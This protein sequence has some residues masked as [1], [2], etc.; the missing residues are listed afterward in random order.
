MK[1]DLTDIIIAV[2]S[3]ISAFATV[4]LALYNGKALTLIKE[5]Q[6]SDAFFRSLPHRM[7]IY[8]NLYKYLDD[9]Q[10][11]D[12]KLLWKNDQSTLSDLK[13]NLRNAEYWYPDSSTT[14][15]IYAIIKG[16]NENIEKYIV[17][18]DEYDKISNNGSAESKDLEDRCSNSGKSL[19]YELSSLL[20]A[21]QPILQFNELSC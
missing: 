3:G 8:D 11:S 17:A 6:H 15:D 13:T 9:F 4:C 21:M 16:L 10:H 5:Q 19:I 18:K 7:E 1:M 14:K 20:S 2:F 12:P